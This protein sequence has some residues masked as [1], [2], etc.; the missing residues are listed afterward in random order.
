MLGRRCL[1]LPSMI[2]CFGVKSESNTPLSPPGWSMQLL[3]NC[4]LVITYW[5]WL[6]NADSS[7]DWTNNRE[8]R[9]KA[10]SAL[11]S[12]KREFYKNAFE[13]N[14][15]YPK[16][17]WNTI[18]TLSGSGKT[19]KGISKLQLVGKLLMWRHCSNKVQPVILLIIAQISVLP[20]VSKV[21]ERHIPN[22]LYAF[23]A[24]TLDR[25]GFVG[26]T[27]PRLL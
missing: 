25:L 1:I 4:T 24:L 16:A 17:T 19:N 7:S 26:Y 18:K 27:V 14:R 6:G 9:N 8:V 23:L 22:S 10:V 20:V 11:R 13:E 2:I 15:N 3:K 5:R 21:I 12:A